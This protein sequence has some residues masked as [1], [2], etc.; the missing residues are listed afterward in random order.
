MLGYRSGVK[1]HGKEEFY[2]ERTSVSTPPGS[3]LQSVCCR[4]EIRNEE[5][6]NS[7]RGRS[8]SSSAREKEEAG[9]EG[10]SEEGESVSS[11]LPATALPPSDE[12]LEKNLFDAIFWRKQSL[13]SNDMVCLVFIMMLNSRQQEVVGKTRHQ[14]FLFSTEREFTRKMY[15]RLPGPPVSTVGRGIHVG[16]GTKLAGAE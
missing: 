1:V 15:F 5:L 9:D 7:K 6:N 4:M 13:A 11:G 2:R 12:I 16:V 10:S 3:P 8:K 14:Q